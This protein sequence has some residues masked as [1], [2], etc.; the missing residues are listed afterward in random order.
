MTF[1]RTGIPVSIHSR[2]LT[3]SLWP[4]SRAKA[5][6]T[7]TSRLFAP[8]PW[9][10]MLQE[11]HRLRTKDHRDAARSF[12][13]QGEDF[14]KAAST[15]STTAAKPLLLYYAFLNIAKALILIRAPLTKLDAARHGLYEKIQPGGKE[16]ISALV[17]TLQPGTKP[18]VFD[19]LSQAV[20]GKHIAGNHTFALPALMR[21]IVPGHRLFIVA[22]KA[23]SENFL[24]NTVHILHEP[25]D[26]TIWPRLEI[27]AGDLTR[28]RLGHT[29]LLQRSGLPW[30]WR[31]VR[32]SVRND[33]LCLEPKTPRTYTK[34]WISDAVM[35]L[36]D[37]IRQNIWQTVLSVPPYRK[38]YLFAPPISE[39]SAT[40][41]QLLSAYALFFYFGSITR[42]RPHHF[43]RILE[44]PYGAFVESFMQNQPA[45][46][47]F[48][49]ASEFAQREVSRAA[50]V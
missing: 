15:A 9:P 36:I 7:V 5:G 41:P 8:D 6:A 29:E 25:S 24:S 12:L 35:P 47:L 42:Y 21:Q 3:F 50:L 30:D 28:L 13:E 11:A 48:L 40:L 10:V 45:Q 49:F 27:E 18:L 34:G 2:K 43:D 38:Y 44:G 14:Y 17:E 23:S 39:A 22:S 31:V 1:A 16:L 46:L 19:L 37:E 26:N 32:D 33:I 20:T 4:V